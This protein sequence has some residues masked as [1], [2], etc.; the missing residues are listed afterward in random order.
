M[1]SPGTMSGIRTFVDRPVG[2]AGSSADVCALHGFASALLAAMAVNIAV[3][4]TGT[5]SSCFSGS[6]ILASDDEFAFHRATAMLSGFTGGF[7]MNIFPYRRQDKVLRR[8][9]KCKVTLTG[10]WSNALLGQLISLEHERSD[11]ATGCCWW[12]TAERSRTGSYGDR[13]LSINSFRG[14]V[15]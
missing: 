12:D 7:L 9:M 13:S 4:P 6:R 2:E 14:C 3:A 10:T 8:S 15:R 5:R 11:G 1:M